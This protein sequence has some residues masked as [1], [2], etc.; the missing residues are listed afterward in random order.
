MPALGRLEWEMAFPSKPKRSTTCSI[1]YNSS[2]ENMAVWSE[3]SWCFHNDLLSLSVGYLIVTLVGLLGY[4][5][6][7]LW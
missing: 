3:D 6:S 2:K 4:Y 1:V 7:F 5:M